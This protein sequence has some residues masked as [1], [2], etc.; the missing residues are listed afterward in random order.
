[1]RQKKYRS[2]KQFEEDLKWFVHNCRSIFQQNDEIQ[3]ASEKLIGFVKDEILTS[4][5]CEEC[6]ENLCESPEISATKQFSKLHLLV[7]NKCGEYVYWP[8]KVL[9]VHADKN[10]I[11][12][13]FFGDNS[14]Y[15]F[16]MES[17]NCYLY[18]VDNAKKKR[19]S[20]QKFYLKAIEGRLLFHWNLN[21]SYKYLY[22]LIGSQWIYWTCPIK[23]R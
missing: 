5:A 2:V 20:R 23:I 7:W 10:M 15:L 11:I 9:A 22:L 4:Q 1:M 13:Q 16:P 3:A 8:A 14:T 12:I 21:L 19:G 18:S 17:N 6:Y